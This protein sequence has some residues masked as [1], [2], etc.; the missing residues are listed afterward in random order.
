[1]RFKDVKNPL[2]GATVELLL[3]GSEPA[4]LNMPDN[5]TIDKSGNILL[6]E[7]PGNNV[8]L[9]RVFA[10]RISD[11][12][13]V[14]IAGFNSALFGADSATKITVDEETSG[15][16]DVTDLLRKNKSDKNSYYV[17]VAQVHST[18]AAARTDITDKAAIASAIEGGQIYLLTVPDWKKIYG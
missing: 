16:T 7:D 13:L 18:I 8:T 5:L 15:I 4:F 9:S 17:F 10:Y 11:A 1:M 12:K 3:D 6:Q 14:Q 2:A